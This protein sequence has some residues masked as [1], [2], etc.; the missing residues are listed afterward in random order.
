M[1]RDFVVVTVVLWRSRS[2]D[3]STDELARHID[4]RCAIVRSYH[5]ARHL[6]SVY[7]EFGSRLPS[8]G[9]RSR[10]GVAEAGPSRSIRDG[11]L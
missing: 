1:M 2:F 7:F 8:A 4:R 10:R 5:L 6:V 9:R 3:G 11:D